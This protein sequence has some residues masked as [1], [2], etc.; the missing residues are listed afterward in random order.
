MRSGSHEPI[1]FSICLPTK[2]TQCESTVIW[3]FLTQLGTT[4]DRLSLPPQMHLHFDF[5]TKNYNGLAIIRIQPRKEQIVIILRIKLEL[6]SLCD[7][8][9]DLFLWVW[10][11]GRAFSP[12]PKL[13]YI[14][15]SQRP[16]QRGNRS[17]VT[18]TWPMYQLHLV[19]F[20]VEISPWAWLVH[21]W[22]AVK[23]WNFRPL[24]C[25]WLAFW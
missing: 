14:R 17:C 12:L 1:S 16:R 18:D 8:W 24:D 7:Y 21:P 6:F 19:H 5:L 20:R 3:L 4:R 13:H 9:V 2:P 23:N 15:L 10:N 25:H 22:S 11:D